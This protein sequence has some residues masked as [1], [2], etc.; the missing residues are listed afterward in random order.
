MKKIKSRRFGWFHRGIITLGLG[1][2]ICLVLPGSARAQSLAD[3]ITMLTLDYQKLSQL[4]KILTDMYS[5]YTIV[6]KGY[7]DIK[8]IAEGNF[9]LHQ[10][11]LDGL[12]AV[13]PLVQ[14][15]Q[16]VANIINNEASLVKEY[17]AAQ[18]YYK[19]QGR[20]TTEELDYMSTMYGNLLTESL[21][22]LD[23]LAMV[24][25]ANQLRMSDAERLAAI[26]RLD[27]DMMDKLTFLRVFNN[28]GVIQGGQRGLEQN[29]INALRSLHGVGN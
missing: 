19:S 16:K 29:D 14:N 21:K 28:N 2:G 11:F 5:F 24:I 7:D 6:S 4:K 26:D 17:K 25:T 10:A 15:Y 23:E 8:N 9:N 18:G 22:D 12:L 27:R 20:F 3:D 13:S 1:V